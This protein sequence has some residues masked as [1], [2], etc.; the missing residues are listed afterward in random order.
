M[1]NPKQPVAH[2]PECSYVKRTED[3]KWEYGIIVS[4]GFN[5]KNEHE[6]RGVCKSY[7]DACKRSNMSIRSC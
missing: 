6:Q 2:N 5:M 7:Q 3:D 4:K 1:T